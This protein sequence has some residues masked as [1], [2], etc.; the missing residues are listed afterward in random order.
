M[1]ADVLAARAFGGLSRVRGRRLLHPRGRVSP[2]EL[3]LAAAPRPTG[4]G[5]LDSGGR[6]PG[7]VRLSRG[8]GLPYDLPDLQGF[9]LRLTDAGG[10]GRHQ[11]LLLDSCLPPPRHRVL[12]VRRGVAGWYSTLLSHRIGGHPCM[13]LARVPDA[14]GP[15]DPVRL[16]V[17]GPA[18]GLL[19]AGTVALGV[20]LSGPGPDGGD[21]PVRFDPVNAGGGI[22]PPTWLTSVR[23]RSYLAAQDTEL[24]AGTA[25][26]PVRRRAAAR[27]SRSTGGGT[28]APGCRSGTA[29]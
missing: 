12:A 5:L 22:D 17:V 20:P 11:D 21:P 27:S 7:L 2:A 18:L 16:L 14:P 10:P 24:S 15:D 9:A 23:H 13:V 29:C 3:H 6:W 19:A 28:A 8:L 26:P 25:V 4:S 1:H